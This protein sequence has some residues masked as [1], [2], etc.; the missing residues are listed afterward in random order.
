MKLKNW[1]KGF[2]IGLILFLLAI[3]VTLYFTVSQYKG[4]CY[5]DPMDGE[6]GG[7]T[8]CSLMQYVFYFFVNPYSVV[9]AL[10]FT[11]IAF[12]VPLTLIG[13]VVDKNGNSQKS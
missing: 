7:T 4:I 2:G 3:L 11:F 9:V 6:L 8:Q 1:Q 10:P 5:L 13:L 12:V